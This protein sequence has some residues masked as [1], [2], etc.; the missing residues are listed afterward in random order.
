MIFPMKVTLS[1]LVIDKYEAK[2][3]CP[4]FDLV[5]SP[6]LLA[7]RRPHQTGENSV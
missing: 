5:E 7:H 2:L 4:H 6:I 3:I 1:P